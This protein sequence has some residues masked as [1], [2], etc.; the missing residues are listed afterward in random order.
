[1][2]KME[3]DNILVSFS[4]LPTVVI[5]QICRY[6]QMNICCSNNQLNFRVY[7]IKLFCK[8]FFH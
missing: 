7:Q 4:P 1:M 8:L 2:I 6:D 5:L 3:I